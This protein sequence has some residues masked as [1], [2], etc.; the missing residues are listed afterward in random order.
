MEDKGK[1]DFS[2]ANYEKCLDS[3]LKNGYTFYKMKEVNIALDNEQSIIMR[4]DVDTQLDV[5]LEMAKIENK[6]QVYSTFFIRFHSHAYNPMC[7]KDAYKIRQISKL[8]H[9]I[10]LHYESDFYSIIDSSAELGMS[11][12]I[13]LLKEIIGKD[14][15][16]IA[17]HE[18]T[19]T[20]IKHVNTQYAESVGIQFQAYDELFFKNF[21]YISDSSCRWRDGSMNYHIENK[22][23]KKLYVLTHPYWWYYT[24]PIENY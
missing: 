23:T 9:E 15:V 17:P 7:L 20:G 12:E 6:K 19:R 18:P 21:K 2:L 16:T 1:N 14:I 8:G 22:T 24:S 3:A 10:G 11:F 13:K 4:H 5:A